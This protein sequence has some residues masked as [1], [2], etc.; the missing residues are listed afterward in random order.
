MSQKQTSLEFSEQLIKGKIAEMIF[1]QMFRNG[2]QFTVIPF[3]YENTFPE[4]AQ[5]ANMADDKEVFE[6]IRNAPDFAIVSHNKREVYLVEV[7]YRSNL[8]DKNVGEMAE[9]IQSKWKSV[10]LFIATPTG[11]YFDSC[12]DITVNHGKINDLE[13]TWVTMNEQKEY[14][15]LLNEF[16]SKPNYQ[17]GH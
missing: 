7:K 2:R 5:Y 6:T 15:R 12:D 16:I 3:G 8:Y 4:M 14:L 13:E 9:K 1:S 11:F 10:K 17:V